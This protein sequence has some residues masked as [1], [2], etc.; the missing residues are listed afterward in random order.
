LLWG[1]Y[2]KLIFASAVAVLILLTGCT[3]LYVKEKGEDTAL[4][5]V[6]FFTKKIVRYQET[7]WQRNFYVV[8]LEY[9][10]VD[11]KKPAAQSAPLRIVGQPLEVPEALLE[12]VLEPIRED[13]DKLQSNPVG[14]EDPVAATID[15][16]TSAWRGAEGKRAKDIAQYENTSA[17]FGALPSRLAMRLGA[18]REVVETVLDERRE[19]YINGRRPLLGSASAEFLLAPDQTLTKAQGQS[20][21]K[22]L[23]TILGALPVSDYVAKSLGIEKTDK[24]DSQAT[25]NTVKSQGMALFNAPAALTGARKGKPFLV[26]D[27]RLTISGKTLLYTIRKPLAA[28]TGIDR[29]LFP[30]ESGTSLVITSVDAGGEPQKSDDS[31][32]YKF[33]GEVRPP[34]PAQ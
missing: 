29:P 26:V 7:Q 24:T 13:L 34:T 15:R 32:A 11:P 28:G 31:K 27:A 8:K 20:D 1:T 5:G 21:S 2:V 25:E 14:G 30:G 16:L 12:V 10:L 6:P 3:T 23:E 33:S 9:S 17:D 19:L 4:P 22:T 18:N